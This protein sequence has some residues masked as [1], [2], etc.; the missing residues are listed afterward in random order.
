MLGAV[1][2]GGD[3]LVR[4][5]GARA[6]LFVSS[7]L[8]GGLMT[9]AVRY[10]CRGPGGF[11]AGQVSMVRFA[12]GVL[13]CLALF[14]LRP[15]TYRP[16]RRELLVTRGLLGGLAVV[17]YFI[18]ISRIGAG[19]ATLLNNT[20]PVFATLIAIGALGER[21]TWKLAA[22]LAL[23]ALGVGVVLLSQ[24]GW[25]TVAFGL[26][27]AAGLLSAILGAGAVTSIR[28]L[29]PT[30]NSPTIFFAFCLGGLAVSWPFALGTWPRA[31]MFWL[32]ALAVGIL[33]VGYQLLMT[34]ALGF[35]KVPEAAV[36]QQMTPVA[37]YLWA[38]LLLDERVSGLGAVG[39]A[40]VIGGVAWG[41]GTAGR[42]AAPSRVPTQGAGKG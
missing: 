5:M 38:A 18:S 7:V 28:A 36:W 21:P 10:A 35:L 1:V 8:F 29:R 11:S 22:A 31:P 4:Q 23:T 39:I 20:H 15:G 40:L 33:A 41:A 26:G 27:E 17:F 25:P 2:R 32:A 16:V 3:A 37:T 24:G 6:Q 42:D 30:D 34:Q 14:E 13:S 12:V 9:V 19:Q